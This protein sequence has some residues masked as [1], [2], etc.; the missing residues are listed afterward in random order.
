VDLPKPRR[1]AVPSA[2]VCKMPALERFDRDP[3]PLRPNT[4]VA[5]ALIQ[6]EGKTGRE[7]TLAIDCACEL[8][9]RPEVAEFLDSKM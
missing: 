1:G 7:L 2:A 4:V 9:D 6:L 8:L 3:G 5:C